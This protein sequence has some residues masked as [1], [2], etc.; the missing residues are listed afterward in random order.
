MTTKQQILSQVKEYI[1]QNI[2]LVQNDKILVGLSGGADSVAL[3][4]ILK[5]LG[6]CCFAAHCHF[7]LRGE[8]SDRDRNFAKQI[9]TKLGVPYIEVKFD[10]LR[11]A[12]EKKISVEMACRE[13]RYEWFETQRVALGCRYLAVAHHRGD[14]VETVLINLIRGTGISG[15]TGISSLNGAVIRPILGLSRE[16]VE[17]YIAL[18]SLSYVIDSSNKE[19]VYVRNKIR[20]RILPLMKEI[21]PSVYEAIEATAVHL[22]ETELIYREALNKKIE[23]MVDIRDEVVYINLQKL[24]SET[25]V[26]TIL[27]EILKPYGF[28]T[29]QLN[30]IISSFSEESGKRFFSLTHRIIK[31]RDK[32]I[33][34][35]LGKEDNFLIY[36]P[37]EEMLRAEYISV[38]ELPPFT[39]DKSCAYFDADKLPQNLILRHWRMG[40]RF[41]PFGMKGTQKLSDYFTTHKFSLIQ[42]ERI[43]L[44]V[45][46]EE[47]LWLVGERQSDKYKVTPSTQR[48][49][50]FTIKQ[51]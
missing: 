32:L 40:D 42:K 33:V 36:Y 5:E 14:S 20:N 3:L 29:S 44:L 9:A 17:N 43:W 21:N 35:P 31:D 47:I 30:D 16:D 24:T 1:Q 45:A 38:E 26:R 7:G 15:L 2:P 27:Y 4:S 13:L 41:L 49:V 48:V 50:K 19:S 6:Y 10:T 34:A 46:G 51:R 39:R 12:A 8:E 11:Y 22:S 23:S 25:A 37:A 18:S 28:L